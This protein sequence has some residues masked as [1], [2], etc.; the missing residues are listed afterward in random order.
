MLPYWEWMKRSP[1]E[2]NTIFPAVFRNPEL[3][4]LIKGRVVRTINRS[5]PKR[6][7]S[8]GGSDGA[9]GL[10]F[11]MR[12][13]V[14][15]AGHVCSIRDSQDAPQT[16]ASFRLFETH[17][18]HPRGGRGSHTSRNAAELTLARSWACSD[19]FTSASI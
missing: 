7:E 1:S 6:A 14:T 2:K 13:Q 16:R 18:E 15:A 12:G 11:L 5:T 3:Q 4:L 19:R 10:T 17:R 9:E 8:G